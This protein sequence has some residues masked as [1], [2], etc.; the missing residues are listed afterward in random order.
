MKKTLLKVTLIC[1]GAILLCGLSSFRIPEKTKSQQNNQTAAI[2]NDTIIT[3]KGEKPQYIKGVDVEG[4][5][6]NCKHCSVELKVDGDA[7][8]YLQLI[9]NCNKTISATCKYKIYYQTNSQ[10]YIIPEKTQTIELSG[11]NSQII[12]QYEI[13]WDWSFCEPLSVDAHFIDTNSNQ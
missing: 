5:Q 4:D 9:N 1:L 11:G 13:F 6:M 2:S 3:P 7:S 8:W 12:D 10:I